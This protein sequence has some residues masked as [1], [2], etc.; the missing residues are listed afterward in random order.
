MS[1]VVDAAK[2]HD[3]GVVL[4]YELPMSSKRL[5]CI[6]TG[7][8]EMLQDNAVIVE[9]KQWENCEDGDGD[10]VVTFLG[11]AD[12]DVLHPAVQVGQYKTYK[13]RRRSEDYAV[14]SWIVA[15]G[16]LFTAA[17]GGNIHQ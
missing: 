7:R 10:K 11:G 4:E 1:Q 9:L 2:L 15:S 6:I 12:R 3:H 13:P 5:D 16:C 8:N 17:V 14:K